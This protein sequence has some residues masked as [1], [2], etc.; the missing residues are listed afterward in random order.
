[1]TSF[2]SSRAVSC[3]PNSFF[4]NHVDHLQE[5]YGGSEYSTINWEAVKAGTEA[6]LPGQWVSCLVA[7]L[8]LWL[9]H[10]VP[11]LFLSLSF[12]PLPPRPGLLP[13]TAPARPLGSH[14]M[15][16]PLSSKLCR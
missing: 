13:L 11:S 9:R 15:R 10:G 2:P 14:R 1:M 4:Q 8:E 7:E 16:P 5:V 6:G 12:L 3:D